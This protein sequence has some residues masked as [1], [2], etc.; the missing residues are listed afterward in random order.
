MTEADWLASGNPIPMLEWLAP[1]QRRGLRYRFR[2][3]LLFGVACAQRMTVH[4]GV[5]SPWIHRIGE[6]ADAF[7]DAEPHVMRAYLDSLP[8]ASEL[9]DIQ[10]LI[11]HGPEIAP[12]SL[13]AQA[14]RLIAAIRE[15]LKL[16]DYRTAYW[17]EVAVQAGILRDIVGNPFRRVNFDPTWRTSDV[18]LLA[19][20]IYEERAFDRMPIL[21]DAI[22]EAGCDNA[23]IL[24]HCRDTNTTHVRGCWVVDLVLGKQ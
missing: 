17:S 5:F 1:R 15:D 22:Q 21:A 4:C 10:L 6:L 13:A 19:R 20:G 24:A 7:P 8:D 12:Q 2:K 16:A 18:E 23:D 14:A 9:L 11:T 3:A